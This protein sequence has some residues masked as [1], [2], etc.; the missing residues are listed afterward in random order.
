MPVHEYIGKND[1]KTW[2][3]ELF[4]GKDESS[5][6]KNIYKKRG[7]STK[8]E[9]SE[10]ENEILYKHNKGTLVK[11]S[12]KLFSTY[13]NEWLS[14]K[15]GDNIGKQTYDN[16]LS[17][18][19]T[20]I[21]P[22]IGNVKLGDLNIGHID[23]VMETVKE[24]GLAA[25]TRIKIYNILNNA[26]K[27]AVKKK[28]MSENVVSAVDKPR[29]TKEQVNVW[30]APTVKRFINE[31]KGLSRYYMACFLP[32]F[33]GCRQGEVLGLRWKDIDF[34]RRVLRITQTLS[35]DGKYFKSGAKSASGVRS[36]ALSKSTIEALLEHQEVIRKEREAVEADYHDH[37]LV[38][39][40]E[41]G[42]PVSPRDIN[43][44][45]YKL[46]DKLGLPKIKYHE[47]RHTHASL[48]LLTNTHPKVVS[49]RLGHSSISIT[50]DIYS[51]LLPH[52]QD[53]AVKKLDDVL[54]AEEAAYM[55]SITQN[56]TA[57][58]SAIENVFAATDTFDKLF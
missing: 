11:P 17:N 42:K 40:K 30:D 2:Y 12:D 25:G 4:L 18:I 22:C 1:K 27:E 37:D 54:E 36:V 44:V 26:I 51:H 29:A 9:A 45:W 34:N 20:H 23:K 53:E 52:M 6:K 50:L 35:H 28:Q 19:N 15:R 8:K 43:K 49:E 56:D 7:F 47:S 10:H 41:D 3:V 21:K 48:L 55:T 14:R 33:T 46:I 57:I 58:E 24:A 5:G 16:Y 38:I 32:L 31:A 39:C 13:L